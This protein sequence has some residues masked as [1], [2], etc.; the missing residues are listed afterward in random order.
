MLRKQ[1]F[2]NPGAQT[3]EPLRDNQDTKEDCSSQL[4]VLGGT[5]ATPAHPESKGIE[6]SRQGRGL[7]S[8]PAAAELLQ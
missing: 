2:S 3:S 1:F 5:A 7:T 4:A 6:P 8:N